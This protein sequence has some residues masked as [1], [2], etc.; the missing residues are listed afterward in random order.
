VS[1]VAL[2]KVSSWLYPQISDKG[3]KGRE[4]ALDYSA[5]HLNGEGKKRF[6][7]STTDRSSAVDA[8][9]SGDDDEEVHPATLHRQSSP[10]DWTSRRQFRRRSGRHRNLET[11]NT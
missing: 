1:Y 5:E 6:I 3:E 8:I 7:P 2:F 9:R 10:D 4:N 11:V